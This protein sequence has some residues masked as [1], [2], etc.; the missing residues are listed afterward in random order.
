MPAFKSLD[1]VAKFLQPKINKA[2]TKE[3]AQK[4]KE[5]EQKNIQTTVYD[6][7]KPK[8]YIRRLEDGGLIDERNMVSTLLDDG[9]LGVR[10]VTPPNPNY[11][12]DALTSDSI[13][14]AVEL[15]KEY[16]F[17]NPGPRPF[18]KNTAQELRNSKEHVE[19]MRVGLK[20]QGLDV[21]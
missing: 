19:A 8:M 4:V 12:H 11:I 16:D 14:E 18:T 10:N 20:N 9:L 6:A 2:L 21:V 3:V 15:G 17:Y 7:Y 5:V 1:D 13:D